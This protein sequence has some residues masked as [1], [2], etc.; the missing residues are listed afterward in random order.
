MGKPLGQAAS[1]SFRCT[2]IAAAIARPAEAKAMAKE[3]P[4]VL[5][6]YPLTRSA[7]ARMASSWSRNDSSIASGR[8]SHD[9]VEPSTSVIRNVTVPDG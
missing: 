1:S 6:M 7:S 8:A 5:K 9:R 4:A 3:S 2:S